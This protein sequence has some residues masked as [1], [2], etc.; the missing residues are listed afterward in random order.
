M[1][2]DADALP[3]DPATL[4]AMLRT[5]HDV[6]ERERA[7][8]AAAEQLAAREKAARIEA[9]T[10]GERLEAMLAALN[11]NRFGP[12]SEQLDPDQLGLGFEDLEQ[13]LAAVAAEA[14][15]ASRPAAPSRPGRRRNLGRLP[16][17]LPRIERVI[18]VAD[19]SCPCCRAT[20]HRIGEDV[21]ERLD[22]VPAQFRVLVVRRPK[23]ACRA[24]EGTLVQAPAPAHVVE[25]G[26]PSEALIAHVVVAKYADHCPL[27][28]QAQ[29]TP[30]RGS[31]SIAP[32][33]PTGLDGRP[34]SSSRFMAACMPI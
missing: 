9:E 27:Y 10:R 2:F 15:R 29:S 13:E 31:I 33:W 8:R 5:A 16:A 12:R 30:A 7:L 25:G 1:V 26:L 23:Y 17:H 14:E 32:R 19:K 18:D 6:I 4:Q 21:A 22:V 20:L 28:R 34:G 24:C 11:R 3:D